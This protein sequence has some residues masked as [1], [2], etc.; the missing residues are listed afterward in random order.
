MEVVDVAQVGIHEVQEVV[1]GVDEEDAELLVLRVELDGLDFRCQL[2]GDRR[3]HGD[4]AAVVEF[5]LVLGRRLGLLLRVL[6]R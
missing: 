2:L 6:Q 4:L 5:H 1:V 3:H